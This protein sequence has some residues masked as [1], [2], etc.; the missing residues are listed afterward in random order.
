[1]KKDF[2]NFCL[3]T[4]QFG[5]D[6][7]L[8]NIR[9][10]Q[11]DDYEIEK[12]F[13][14]FF[15]NGGRFIDTARNY[16]NSEKRVSKYL[17]SNTKIISK[18]ELTGKNNLNKSMDASLDDLG[19]DKLDTALLHNPEILKTDI[20]A[21]D[22]LVA[23]KENGLCD[24]VGISIYS[25]KDI[26]KNLHD[27]A[28]KID[29]IQISGNAFDKRFFDNQ[30][31]MDTLYANNIRIDIR[32]IFL[33]GLLLQS[34]DISTSLFPAFHKELT[35]WHS[36][37]EE[38]NLNNLEASILNIPQTKSEDNLIIFGCRSLQEIKQT[39]SAI[40]SKKSAN[41]FKIDADINLI[42]PR[43]WK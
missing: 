26:E 14:F 9:D 42:D 41:K 38:N 40:N 28:S 35:E 33:Q 21:L 43:L 11:I 37:C 32:S 12:I 39:Y 23:L 27:I 20:S 18:F 25:A 36:Y 24:K 30:L 29:V 22:E 16:G 15:N 5:K 10:S 19:V 34:L 8:R 3:G 1:M 13:N 6:Y 2:K 31:I 7:G 4:V 17:N